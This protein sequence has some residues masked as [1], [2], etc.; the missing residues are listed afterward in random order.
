MTT[1]ENRLERMGI[2][3]P[4]SK[5]PLA[6]YVPCVQIGNMLMVSG[7]L[8][9]TLD[10]R[11]DSAHRGKLGESVTLEQGREAAK[12]CALQLFA[13][14]KEFLGD[15]DRLRRCLRLGGFINASSSFSQ[16]PAVMNGA[17]DFMVSVLGE[18]GGRHVR[19]TVGV[20]A[21]P[22][23]VCIEVEGVFELV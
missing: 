15:L 23:D 1:I 7:Q 18:E 2:V 10:G 20:A 3:L 16:L 12:F 6:N 21:L 19:T 22:L 4:Q 13:Q 11:I 9:Y 17:S 14:V 8:P 5:A